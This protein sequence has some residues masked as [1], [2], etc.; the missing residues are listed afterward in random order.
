LFRVADNTLSPAL[1][2]GDLARA[3]RLDY[4]VNVAFV[5]H[6]IFHSLPSR[7]DI[8]R[9]STDTG[10]KKLGLVIG[11]PNEEIGVVDGQVY[12][13]RVPLVDEQPPVPFSGDWPLTYAGGMSILI[14][15]INLGT[16]RDVKEVPLRSVTGKVS[17]VI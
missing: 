9:Y 11:L 4:T 3:S 13:N 12:S 2:K 10:E 1:R 14:A 5:G 8:V 17:K 6:P 7:F 15:E 16:I